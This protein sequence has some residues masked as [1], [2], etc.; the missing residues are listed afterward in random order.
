[1]LQNKKLTPA[2]HSE[3]YSIIIIIIVVVILCSTRPPSHKLRGFPEGFV[4]KRE[5]KVEP[6]YS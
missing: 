6:M 1:M 2:R 5:V 3:T 4:L